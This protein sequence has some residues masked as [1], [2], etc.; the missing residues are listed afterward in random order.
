MFRPASGLSAP[1]M[2]VAQESGS[3][4]VTVTEFLR[5]SVDLADGDDCQVNGEIDGEV[6]CE[7]DGE[8][9]GELG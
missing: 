3:D 4:E 6:D 8:V 1:A 7:V 5:Q 9:D 2:V